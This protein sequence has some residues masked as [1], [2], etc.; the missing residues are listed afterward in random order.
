MRRWIWKV[1]SQNEGVKVDF[2]LLTTRSLL[3]Y[4]IVPHRK[5][6]VLQLLG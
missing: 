4:L 5:S 3:L 2:Y 6:M 1:L